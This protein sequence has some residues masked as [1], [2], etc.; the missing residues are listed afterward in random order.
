M[1]VTEAV[2]AMDAS[3]KPMRDVLDA[4]RPILE[5]ERA[6]SKQLS[7]FDS[8]TRSLA[9]SVIGAVPSINVVGPATSA[10]LMKNVVTMPPSVVDAV[11]FANS[12]AVD[13]KMLSI[14]KSVVGGVK[15]DLGIVPPQV[16]GAVGVRNVI[17]PSAFP[18][19]IGVY[20]APLRASAKRIHKTLAD[21]ALLEAAVS[22]ITLDLQRPHDTEEPA[23]KVENLADSLGARPDLEATLSASLAEERHLSA[24]HNE[25]RG[26]AND[27]VGF[28]KHV[29][30]HRVSSSG[31]VLGGTVFIVVGVVL[32]AESGQAF[33][34]LFQA[35]SGGAGVYVFCAVMS[36][37]RHKNAS[38][39]D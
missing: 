2:D 10:L 25:A 30:S 34:S 22:K 31:L 12:V 14:G 36:T 5:V 20:N 11:K 6:L 15:W 24:R 39:D 33:A 7:V 13:T 27:V 38:T 9:S 4:A 18:P 26:L 8:M 19:K 21:D 23:R 35:V 1:S 28:V 16:L 29:L 3:M 37:A 32:L 17:F